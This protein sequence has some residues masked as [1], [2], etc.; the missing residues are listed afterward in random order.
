MNPRAQALSDK[1]QAFNREMINCVQDCSD[2]DWQRTCKAEDWPVGVVARHV[3]HGHYRVVELAKMIIKGDPLPEWTMADVVKM[4]NDHAREHAACTR[5]EVLA[6]I[7]KKGRS[8]IEYINTLSEEELDRKG[9][10]TLAGG[11]I[12]AQQIMEMLILHSGGEHL[13]S[14]RNTISG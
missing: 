7:E 3:G 2:D 13:E 12:S 14:I 9:Q 5:E 10:M 8:L 6:I 1:I 4:G 11:A